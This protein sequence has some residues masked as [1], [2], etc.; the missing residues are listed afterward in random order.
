M[1]RPTQGRAGGA[2]P[3][4]HTRIWLRM[5]ACFNLVERELRSSLRDEFGV[6]LARFDVLAQVA[7]PPAEPTMGELSRRLKVTKGNIT[8][9]VGRL[10]AD[11]LVERRRD[12]HDA[13]TQRVRLSARGRRLVQAAIPVHNARLTELLAALD[14]DE[15]ATL[16]ALLGRLRASLR[17]T[18]GA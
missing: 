18:L 2:A 13:R 7:R 14:A 11:G 17:E 12:P 8:D 6:S 5:L 9:V 1:N 10:E 16:D 4:L 15:L 3:V